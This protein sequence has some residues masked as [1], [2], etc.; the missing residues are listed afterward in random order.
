[1]GVLWSALEHVNREIGVTSFENGDES[2]G[3]FIGLQEM[4]LL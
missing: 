3:K 4:A 1:L 2:L